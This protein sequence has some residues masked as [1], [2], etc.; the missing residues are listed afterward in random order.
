MERLND[1]LGYNNLKIFQN[2]DFF[3]FS[4]DSI[5]LANYCNIRLKDKKIIDFC[6]GNAVIPLILSKRCD[7]TI[8][9]V[10]IQKKLYDLAIKSVEYNKLTDRI[11]IFCDDI[12]HFCNKNLYN[13]YDLVLCNPPFFPVG[14][15]NNKNLSFEKMIARHE[16]KITLD[17]V[18]EC[19]SK[20]LKEHGNFCI[21]H[22]ADRLLDVFSS[23]RKWGI[24]PKRI[25][26]VYEYIGKE[27]NMVL[28]E[29]QKRGNV[30]LKVDSPLIMYNDD[31][32]LSSEYSKLQLEVRQ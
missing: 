4:L 28:I 15:T 11:H 7:K 18:C 30:G 12:N 16:V 13:T 1:I 8:E 3:S 20:I 17:Q 23:F 25:K 29:G 21:V 9:G 27:S 2:T 19:A 22:R 26:F 32:S 5:V 14:S 10:E 6:T 31:G 24:E